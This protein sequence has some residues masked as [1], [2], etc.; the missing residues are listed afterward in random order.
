MPEKD[1]I[2][3][4]IRF[5]AN[6]AEKREKGL[7]FAKPLSD[8]EAAFFVFPHIGSYGFWNRNVSFPL[9]LAFIDENGKIIGFADMEANSPKTAGSDFT[10]TKYVIEAKQGVFKKYDINENDLVIFDNDKLLIKKC[11][12]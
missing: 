10:E 7:M 1:I 11:S 5:I 3:F 12:R 4:N 2:I 6:T 9:S 8:T